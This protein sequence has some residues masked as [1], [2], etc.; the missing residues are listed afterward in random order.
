MRNTSIVGGDFIKNCIVIKLD[1]YDTEISVINRKMGK[2]NIIDN[3]I[4][5]ISY[6]NKIKLKIMIRKSNLSDYF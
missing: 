6:F 4:K 3:S 2:I 1:D 5:E